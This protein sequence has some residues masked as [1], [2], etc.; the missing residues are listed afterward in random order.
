M[1]SPRF[2]GNFV[3]DG[4]QMAHTILK[5]SLSNFVREKFKLQ[6]EEMVSKKLIPETQEDVEI[7]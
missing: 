1:G 3:G 2:F 5:I 4:A 7:E 6:S